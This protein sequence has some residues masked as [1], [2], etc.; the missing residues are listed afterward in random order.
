MINLEYM[1]SQTLSPRPAIL[2]VAGNIKFM[3]TISPRMLLSMTSPAAAVA[4]AD[5]GVRA[6]IP[7]DLFPD[8]RNPTVV[9]TAADSPRL[10]HALFL[11][12]LIFQQQN[13]RRY[14]A[15]RLCP[16]KQT[17]GRVR[18]AGGRATY[19]EMCRHAFPRFRLPAHL[20]T[21]RPPAA[22]AAAVVECTHPRRAT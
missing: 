5:H 11:T 7:L 13:A 15:A 20:L 21:P 2:P 10:P 9:G 18:T 22:A 16:N 14:Y 17:P 12:L 1:P 4:A 3:L 8:G 6:A 19:R